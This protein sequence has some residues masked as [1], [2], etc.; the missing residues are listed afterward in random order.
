M[1]YAHP[2][3]FGTPSH[4]GPWERVAFAVSGVE[5]KLNW[6]LKGY[7]TVPNMLNMASTGFAL[8]PLSLCLGFVFVF[9]FLKPQTIRL[10]L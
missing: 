5:A 1:P 10:H 7:L 3:D 4:I 8:L 6:T 9:V 2:P